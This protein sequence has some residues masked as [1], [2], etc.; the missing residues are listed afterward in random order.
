M[1]PVH[2]YDYGAI[3]DPSV[4]N[5]LAT[6]LLSGEIQVIAFTS[7]PQVRVLFDLAEQGGIS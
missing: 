6:K 1:T 5:A 3:A 4:V 7:A 2:I